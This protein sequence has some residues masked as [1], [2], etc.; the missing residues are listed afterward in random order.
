MRFMKRLTPFLLLGALL[1]V[2]AG[3]AHAEET[4]P[5]PVGVGYKIGNGLGFLGADILLRLVPHVVFDLQANYISLAERVYG[6]PSQTVTGYGLAPTVQSQLKPIGHTP[7][8]G[9]GM[10][11]VHESLNDVTASATGLLVNA[12]YEWRFASHVGVLVGGGIAYL[13]KIS[14]TNGTSTIEQSGGFHP[15]LE[16]GVRYYF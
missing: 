1:T 7:Y 10:V 5:H 15:N 11:Y 3:R 2:G 6:G 13:G 9:I 16:V 4:E 8:L 12:G 14:A